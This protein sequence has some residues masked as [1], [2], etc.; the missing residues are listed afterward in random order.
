[1]SSKVSD[2]KDRRGASSAEREGVRT[3]ATRDREDRDLDLPIDPTSRTTLLDVAAIQIKLEL[4]L[5]VPVD[6]VTPRHRLKRT[7]AGLSPRL[8]PY[9]LAATRIDKT[10][11]NRVLN[12]R[13]N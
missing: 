12:L 1:M 11:L 4:Q 8:C 2:H 5:G 13:L 9:E 3:C 6:V 7:I 10:V